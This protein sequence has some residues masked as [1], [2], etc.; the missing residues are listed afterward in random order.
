MRNTRI[1]IVGVVLLIALR[2]SLG[3]HFYMEGVKKL[4]HSGFTSTHLLWQATG[5]L[6][7]LYHGMIP[8][9]DGRERLDQAATIN[10][11]DLY[12]A[13]AAKHLDFNDQQKEDAAKVLEHAESALEFYFAYSDDDLKRV[14]RDGKNKSGHSLWVMPWSVTQGMTDSDLNALIAALRL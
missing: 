1:G 2:L 4:Q 10:T 8:D 12:R 6:A 11:W 7:P 13:R 3:W 14:F 9:K 5:P